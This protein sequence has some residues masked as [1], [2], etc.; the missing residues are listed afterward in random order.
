MRLKRLFSAV[1]FHTVGEPARTIVGGIPSIPG[2]AM[3]AKKRYIEDHQDDIRQLLTYEPRGHSAMSGATLTQPTAPGADIGLVS[4]E[5]SGCL[6]MRGHDTIAACTVLVET[7]ILP[8]KEPATDLVLDPPAGI[9][10]AQVEVGE[11]GVTGVTVQNVPA[12][13]F[14]KDVEVY[15]P[16]VGRVVVD[17]SCGGNSC[18]ILP[19][20]M[21]AVPLEPQHASNFARIGGEIRVP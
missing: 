21:V 17:I 6:P 15:V 2:D 11:H 18:A 14:L 19:A 10:R 16:G 12:F 8:A 3:F 13:L 5:V 4:I 9:L 1:D 20:E 7:G